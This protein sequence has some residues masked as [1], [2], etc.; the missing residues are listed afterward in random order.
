MGAAD[1]IN[2]QKRVAQTDANNGAHIP[3]VEV[4]A[5][6]DG[7]VAYIWKISTDVLVGSNRS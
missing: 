7:F 4:N 2:Q 5:G 6:A 1:L 3:D